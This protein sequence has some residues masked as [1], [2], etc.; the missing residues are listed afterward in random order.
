MPIS[1]ANQSKQMKKC[2]GKVKRMKKGGAVKKK[3]DSQIW[4]TINMA[5]R[6]RGRNTDKRS[7]KDSE[8]YSTVTVTEKPIKKMAKG[9]RVCRGMGCATR[10]GKFSKNG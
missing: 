7:A 8:T 3:T 6:P 9:G 4:Q 2:G 10:G 5:N 1:R